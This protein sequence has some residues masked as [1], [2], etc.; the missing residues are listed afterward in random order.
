MGDSSSLLGD[1]VLL[2]RM[3]YGYPLEIQAKMKTLVRICA[4][5]NPVCI[6]SYNKEGKVIRYMRG[7]EANQNSGVH[8]SSTIDEVADDPILQH[9][10]V[11]E[12][13]EEILNA[14]KEIKLEELG[15]PIVVAGLFDEVFNI[16]E[17]VGTEPHTVNLCAGTLGK[18]EL[19]P[20]DSVLE[21][22]TMCGHGRVSSNLA[23]HLIERIR[24]KE[25]TAEEAA[26]EIGKQC[27]CNIFN[28][29]RGAKIIMD[30]V[31]N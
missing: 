17:I 4:R 27:T 7:W 19:L 5:H 21:L 20:E 29:V 25:I 26:L 31:S 2:A 18:L 3:P 13:K 1:W 30:A 11:Y 16:C 12:K 9:H 15:I 10:V 22:V 8:I 23:L 14:V 24:E 6:S 28:P